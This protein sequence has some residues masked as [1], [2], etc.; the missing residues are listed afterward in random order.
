MSFSSLLA[1]SWQSKF[2]AEVDGASVLHN[3]QPGCPGHLLRV[4]PRARLS[5]ASCF[6]GSPSRFLN[7]RET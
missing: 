3:L 6:V 1:S 5:P 7:R 2:V 4:N